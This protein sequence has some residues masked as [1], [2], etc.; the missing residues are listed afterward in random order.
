MD[1]KGLR[2]EPGQTPESRV[3]RF[4]EGI[5][6]ENEAGSFPA[7]DLVSQQSDPVGWLIARV[8]AVVIEAAQMG[9]EPLTTKAGCLAAL[10]QAKALEDIAIELGFIRRML[11]QLTD[12]FK[13][14]T[15]TD[16]QE[17]MLAG[18]LAAIRTRAV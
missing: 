5:N 12:S 4:I 6:N 2:L 15:A 18:S 8:D 7:A 1:Q 14:V 11:H 9:T 17:S 10:Y 16:V 13:D 3:N